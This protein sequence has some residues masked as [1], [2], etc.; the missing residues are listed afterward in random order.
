MTSIEQLR[1]A[2]CII[3]ECIS[4]SKA[5]GLNMPGSDTDIKGIFVLP[6][7]QFYGLQY[8]GQVSNETNDIVFYEIGRFMELLLRNNP[9]IIE[10]LGTTKECILHRDPIMD[11]IKTEDFLSK[12]CQDSFAKYAFSQ[13]KKARGLNKKIFNPVEH[14]R[15]TPLDFCYIMLKK[16]SLPLQQW[17]IQEKIEPEKCGLVRLDHIRDVYLLYYDEFGKE[18]YKGILAKQ[19]ANELSLSAVSK[20]REPLVYLYFNKDAYSIYCKEYKEYWNW[21]EKRNELRYQNTL[22][23]DKQYDAKNMM[24]TFRLLAMAKEIATGM[25]VQTQ[26]PDREFL[27]QIRSGYFEYNTLMEMA[28]QQLLEISKLFAKAILPESPNTQK[29]EEILIEMRRQFYQRH[30]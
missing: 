24:H 2:G 26:R 4:G 8:T 17:L 12:R 10:L 5:Y 27:L 6:Q 11:L 25:G 20:E 15:K 22:E 1:E 14:E 13:I 28:D 16:G 3:F 19:N 18:D 9:N 23:Q 30:T 29:A 21:V 7:D